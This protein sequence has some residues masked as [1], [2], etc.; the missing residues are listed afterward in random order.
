MIVGL[1]IDIVETDRI[2]R[3]WNRFGD[4]FT[5]KILTEKERH[6][7]DTPSVPALAARFAAKEA[8]VKAL[9]TGFSHG[10]TPK[11]LEI[12]SDA[13]GKPQIA[14]FGP[15]RIQ[16]D[17]LGVVFCHVSMTHGR[18]NAVAVVVLETKTSP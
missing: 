16:A 6:A 1:G 15:A 17:V 11:C 10:I 12:L 2:A 3:I 4:H 13:H 18:D 8:G 14:F 7:L 9:G 5:R